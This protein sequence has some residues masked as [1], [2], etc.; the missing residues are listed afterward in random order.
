MR[1]GREDRL[2]HERM[3]DALL[4]DERLVCRTDHV[5]E[6]QK[7]VAELTSIPSASRAGLSRLRPML[8]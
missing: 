6:A 4:V 8:G 2:A 7:F 1:F 3:V 5:G